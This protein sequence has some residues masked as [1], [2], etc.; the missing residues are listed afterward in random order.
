MVV[1]RRNHRQ[2]QW[3][4]PR[5]FSSLVVLHYQRRHN[6]RDSHEECRVDKLGLRSM[7]RSK[8]HVRAHAHA[9][10]P[11]ALVPGSHVAVGTE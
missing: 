4:S 2:A 5:C 8:T 9:L 1:F 6:S 7:E 3:L 11:T 10:M